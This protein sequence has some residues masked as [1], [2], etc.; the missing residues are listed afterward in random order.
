M[1]LSLNKIIHLHSLSLYIS[2]DTA[3][4]FDKRLVS[5]LLNIFVKKHKVTLAERGNHKEG[6]FG[7]NKIEL[8]KF[9]VVNVGTF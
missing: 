4:G 3:I 1:N 2:I 5:A 6:I 7:I 8:T 9:K